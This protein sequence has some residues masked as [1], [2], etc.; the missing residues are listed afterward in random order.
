MH[1]QYNIP[2]ILKGEPKIETLMKEIEGIDPNEEWY[3]VDMLKLMSLCASEA[4]FSSTLLED[5][6][7]FVI[8]G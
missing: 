5:L 6:H 2:R 7:R 1:S 4:Y 3:I 8:I